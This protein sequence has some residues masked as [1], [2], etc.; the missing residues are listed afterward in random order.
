[1]KRALAATFGHPSGHIAAVLAIIP[2]A[3]VAWI[4]W[5]NALPHRTATANG[6]AVGYDL[7]SAAAVWAAARHPRMP[8]TLARAWNVIALALLSYAA[9]DGLWMYYE[10]VLGIDPWPS[11]ADVL[12]LLFYPLMMAGM[13]LFPHAPQGRLE[14]VKFWLDGSTVLIGGWMVVWYFVLGPT[15][16]GSSELTTRI[17]SAAYPIGDLV[18]AFGATGLALRSRRDGISASL[19]VLAAGAFTF[20]V[21]DIVFGY[22]SILERYEGGS[23]VDVLYLLARF[24]IVCGATVGA[25]LASAA[26]TGDRVGTGERSH[27]DFLPLLAVT[28]GYAV[29]FVS[30]RSSGSAAHAAP[31]LYGAIIIT[32]LVGIR[33]VITARENARL[34]GQLR[35]VARTDELTGL[36]SRA[37]FVAQAERE[38][39]RFRRYRQPVA[40]IVLDLDGFKDINDRYGHLAGDRAL[41]HVAGELSEGLRTTDLIARYG[42]D[43]FIVLLSDTDFRGASAT[44]SRIAQR[45][46]ERPFLWE[47]R[48]IRLDISA[49]VAEAQEA[50]PG[51]AAT[52]EDADLRMYAAKRVRQAV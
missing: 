2:V 18:L 24:T 32:L 20:F 48:E 11:P 19:A 25:S 29:L 7:L 34:V 26:Q 51:L 15:V 21:A 12:Y 50:F 9:G 39:A 8:R 46:S 3:Y 40:I 44:A 52:I 38:F 47:G 43:E 45:I 30:G 27:A 28:L 49:G 41:V 36:L 17:M 22:L 35:A 13:L 6:I 37:E 10:N 1:M 42:G 31:L 14:R 5:G 23:W 33:E 16:R 4:I